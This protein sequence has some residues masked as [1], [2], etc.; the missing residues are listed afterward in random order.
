MSIIKKIFPIS[1]FILLNLIKLIKLEELY[2]PYSDYKNP[3]IN[4]VYG[5]GNRTLDVLYRTKCAELCGTGKYDDEHCCEGNTIDELKCVSFRRCQ[6]IL[7]NFQ[8]Y[9]LNIAVI[10]YFSLLFIT[11]FVIFIVYFHYTKDK[12]FKCKNACSSSV[13]V[14][15]AGTVI[16]IT[17]IQ[18]YCWYKAISIE[19][20]FGAKFSSCVNVDNLLQ[21]VDVK[22]D[23]RPSRVSKDTIEQKY[24]YDRDYHVDNKENEKNLKSN[25]VR[26]NSYIVEEKND[27]YKEKEK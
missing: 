3:T 18:F 15:C 10:S 9:V 16:P 12:K 11:M 21:S 20:F 2:T 6:E 25:T 8:L 23:E 24:G 22:N 7:D 1:F 17:I 4:S 5:T 14:F 19:Q 13:I 27:Y 26:S